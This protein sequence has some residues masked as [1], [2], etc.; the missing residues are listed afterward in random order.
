[1][2]LLETL[3]G[4]PALSPSELADK[5]GLPRTTGYRLITEMVD[6]GL[7]H[8]SSTGRIEPGQRLWQ[9]AQQT[10]LNRTL[11]HTALPFM[12]DVN[13][14]VRHTTQLAVLTNT[15]VLIVE[16]LSQHGAVVNPAEV[17]G[18]MP[19]HLTS[20]G[21][22]LLAFAPEE[23][24]QPWFSAHHELVKTERPALHKELAETRARGFTRLS[25]QINPETTGLSV[26]VLDARGHAEAALTVVVPRESEKI[27]QFL[28]A[29]QTASHGISRALRDSAPA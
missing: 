8:R 19:A 21:H 1:M 2:R 4:N 9:V 24:A 23:R 18:T 29:L 22:V 10:R 6:L 3:Q 26:P 13:A 25:G 20:M 14:V 17:A 15:G 12:Q 11:R 28:M 7:L 5:A 16:R 27:P